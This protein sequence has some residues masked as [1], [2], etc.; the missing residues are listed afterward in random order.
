MT[1]TETAQVVYRIMIQQPWGNPVVLYLFTKSV[2]GGLFLCALILRWLGVSP[3]ADRTL[4]GRWLPLAGLVFAAL[5]GMIL[6]ADLGRPERFYYLFLYTHWTSALAWGSWILLLFG[7]AAA[8]YL[9]SDVF[10]DERI[11]AITLWLAAISGALVA[12]YTGVLFYQA[13]GRTVWHNHI[14][15]L[16]LL[17]HALVAG[18]AV[19]VLLAQVRRC[20]A[21]SRAGALVLGLSLVISLALSVSEAPALLAAGQPAGLVWG[22]GIAA[23]AA[24][25]LFLLALRSRMGVLVGAGARGSQ[26]AATAEASGPAGGQLLASGAAL[27]ALIGLIAMQYALVFAGQA[28]PQA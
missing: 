2:L 21:V 20:L 18:S 27:L 9:M 23:G 1:V 22:V 19:L 17:V 8:L 4:T 11:R 25:P 24:L 10:G 28:L 13:P 7:V 16:E 6:I 3:D 12:S 15:P 26:V 5:T 14:L